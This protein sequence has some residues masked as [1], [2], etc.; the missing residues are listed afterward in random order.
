LGE[1][2]SESLVFLGYELSSVVVLLWICE[3]FERMFFYILYIAIHTSWL[4]AGQIVIASYDVR[5]DTKI[6][7]EFIY[8]FPKSLFFKSRVNNAIYFARK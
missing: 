1:L 2:T 8:T 4:A 6:F 5:F 7:A 3:D